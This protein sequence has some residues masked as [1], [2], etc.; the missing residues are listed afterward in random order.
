METY[1]SHRD[2][3]IS[4]I[5]LKRKENVD[6]GELYSQLK[7]YNKIKVKHMVMVQKMR[8]DKKKKNIKQLIK[9]K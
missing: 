5:I 6:I 7:K 2:L 3:G 8:I 1:N 9:S 4:E